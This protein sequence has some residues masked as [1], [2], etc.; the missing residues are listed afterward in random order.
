[1]TIFDRVGHK[2]MAVISVVVSIGL[3][4]VG[5]Y[6]T[7]EQERTVLAQNERTMRT[8]TES[9][10]SGLQSVMLAGYADIAHEFANQLRKVPDVADF[11][12]ARTDGNEAFLDNKTIIDVNQRRGQEI[13]LPR[14]KT[15]RVVLFPADDAVLAEVLAKKKPVARYNTGADGQRTLTF[16]APIVNHELCYKCHGK[17]EPLRGLIKLTT[18]LTAGK[19]CPGKM[20]VRAHLSVGPGSPARPIVWVSMTPSSASKL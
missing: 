3:V 7:I 12:I 5:V 16:V 11:R 15:N 14:E 2:I 13:F 20:Y 1:M 8:L 18:S 17:A 19:W 6:Y 4:S 10:I 9:V